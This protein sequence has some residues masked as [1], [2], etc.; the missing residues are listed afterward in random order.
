MGIARL[1]ARAASDCR[2]M[3]QLDSVVRALGSGIR[4]LPV[5]ELIWR[6]T[7]HTRRQV[8]GELFHY[9]NDY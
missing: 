3:M 1:S 4:R 6:Q 9:I 2:Q 8:E 7:W 5:A